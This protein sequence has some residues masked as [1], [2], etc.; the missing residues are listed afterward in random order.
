MSYFNKSGYRVVTIIVA[1]VAL[2]VIMPWVKFPFGTQP[3]ISKEIIFHDELLGQWVDDE[4]DPIETIT[5]SKGWGKSYILA[6]DNGDQRIHFK[7]ILVKIGDYLFLSFPPDPQEIKKYFLLAALYPLDNLGLVEI[8]KNVVSLRGLDEQWL[9]GREAEG[10]IVF[11]KTDGS[12]QSWTADS[13][14]I[15]SL[16]INYAL[17]EP[18]VAFS[19]PIIYY[20]V[21]KH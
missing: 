3:L 1:I 11:R 10:Q 16:L 13:K 15:R 19:E 17:K 18:G 7:V 8:N 12:A 2:A 21:Q 20:K 9:E 5:F 14:Q 4:K 6:L